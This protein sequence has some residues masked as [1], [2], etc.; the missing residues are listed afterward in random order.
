MASPFTSVAVSLLGKLQFR[1]S[2]PIPRRSLSLLATAA[3]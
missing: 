2:L 3:P 1:H